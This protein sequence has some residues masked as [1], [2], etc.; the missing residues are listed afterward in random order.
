MVEQNHLQNKLVKLLRKDN[1]ELWKPPY[2]T[3]NNEEEKSDLKGLSEKYAPEVGFNVTQVEAALD[4]IRLSA[5]RKG[6]GNEAYKETGIATLYIALPKDC[7]KNILEMQL[8]IKTTDLMTKINEEFG[9]G[10][11]MKLIFKG[12]ELKVDK[13]LAEQ[14]IKHNSKI[15]VL[16]LESKSKSKII[17]EEKQNQMLKR[18]QKGFQIL[19]NRDESMDPETT[20][21]L[22]IAD[23]KGNPIKFPS[24]EKKA[25]IMAIGLHEKGRAFLKKKDYPMA[26]CFL[27]QADEKFDVCHSDLLESVDNYAVLQLDIVWCYRALEQMSLLE[28]AKARL[29]KAEDAFLKC[30][31]KD[32]ERLVQIKGNSRGEEVLFLRLY[33]LQ[34]LLSYIEGNE[35]AAA[36]KL[37]KVQNLHMQLCIDSS[38]IAELM[39]LGYTEQEAR[40]GLRACDGNVNNAADHICQRRE[41]KEAVRRKEREKRRKRMDDISSL[42]QLGYSRRNAAKALAKAGGDLNKAFQDLLD[43]YPLIATENNNQR[44]NNNDMV[45]EE[46]IN[47][48]VSLGFNQDSAEA[49]LRHANGNLE[50][51][52]QLLLHYNGNLPENLMAVGAT[53]SSTPEDTSIS[54]EEP[55]SSSAGSPGNSEDDPMEA[56]LIQEVLADIPEHEEDY[57]DLTLEEEEMVIEQLKSYLERRNQ[58]TG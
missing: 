4:D 49:A 42:T 58:S 16:K 34:G 2:T 6:K 38:K 26:L 37:S 56:D 13:T 50:S 31:G 1:I 33:L 14:N 8:D 47:Q 19:S 28:D 22:E 51:A 48:V 20:P 57:L 39:N 9:L 30:Y 35:N 54:S 15:M 24:E 12:K 18:S 21:Y 5:V 45:T 53:S 55:S 52:I 46:K 3:E 43:N 40:L 27:L 25:L 10:I 36:E 7:K 44:L 32:R 29:Q 11:E 23:Q 41:E 17:E